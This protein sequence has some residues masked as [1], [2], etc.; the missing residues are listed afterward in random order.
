MSAPGVSSNYARAILKEALSPWLE[1]LRTAQRSLR[2]GASGE[3][4][5]AK[6][7]LALPATLRPE[8]RRFIQ[9]LAREDDLDRLPD[10]IRELESVYT[11]GRE[12][13]VAQVT[14]AVEMT[15]TEREAL[16]TTLRQRFGQDLLFEYA[17][18]PAVIG[19]V[20][21]RI[22]DLVIDGTVAGRLDAMRE[23]MVGA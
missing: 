15:S 2:D 6:L 14:A 1:S 16:E 12:T 22:G 13:P 5:P 19:G 20:R 4:D 21:V 9:L 17:V 18:D 10:I 8:A 7:A 11:E 23:R 3:A